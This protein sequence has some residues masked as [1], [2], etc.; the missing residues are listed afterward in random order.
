[1]NGKSSVEDARSALQALLTTSKASPEEP[2]VNGGADG[3]PGTALRRLFRADIQR[4]LRPPAQASQLAAEL[5]SQ[6]SRLLAQAPVAPAEKHSVAPP[7]P[8]PAVEQVV[9]GD[10]EDDE[11]DEEDEEE[12]LLEEQR[13]RPRRKLIREEVQAADLRG[14]VAVARRRLHDLD[15]EVT[16]LTRRLREG[17][18]AAWNQQK[19]HS[20]AE[21]KIAQAL[22][23]R[24]GELKKEAVDEMKVLEKEELKLRQ[25]LGE[26]KAQASRWYQEA[27]H[28]DAILQQERDAQKGGDAHRIL[29]RHPAGEVFLPSF[30]S[31]ND[32]D[33]DYYDGPPPRRPPP[34]S[35]AAAASNGRRAAAGDSSDEDSDKDSYQ[36]PRSAGGGGP[37]PPPR[38]LDDSDSDRDE[39]EA[40]SSMV[41]PAG[42]SGSLSGMLDKSGEDH[43]AVTNAGPPARA[44]KARSD[45]ESSS[46]DED[47][48]P[49]WKSAAPAASSTT[50]P[51]EAPVPPLPAVERRPLRPDE[52]DV[53]EV[54]SEEI[55]DEE[56]ESSRSL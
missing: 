55:V 49:A 6:V 26:V 34:P 17:R 48:G 21:A 4:S 52:D 5:E 16:A 14:Q 11:E 2:S 32:S 19:L 46:E 25:S 42:E 41:S 23:A 28:Q 9:L 40:G 50:A 37:P 24:S 47:P 18:Q 13:P 45:S 51:A 7:P 30:P 53:E 8:P 15:F 38:R 33:D 22:A 54:S 27:R 36:R 20:S 29:A 12:E 39:S 3:Q 43:A 1:M 10:D 31:D 56:L 44:S 35:S